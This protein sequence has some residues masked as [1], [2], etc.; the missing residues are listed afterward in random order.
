VIE[1]NADQ[2]P[3]YRPHGKRVSCGHRR[4]D[5]RTRFV[6]RSQLPA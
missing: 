2:T 1:K 6:S 3:L 5:D 4:G